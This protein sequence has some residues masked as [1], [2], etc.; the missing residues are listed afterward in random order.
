MGKRQA[1]TDEVRA[2]LANYELGA[3]LPGVA[4]LC[5]T[6]QVSSA[7]AVYAMRALVEEGLLKSVQGANGGYFVSAIPARS[8][9][10]ILNDLAEHL[11]AA[12]TLLRRYAA[13]A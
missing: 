7:T 12:A 6:Y 10:E 8:G 13:T 9:C 11:E 1:I 4:E 2:S 5:E 3:K